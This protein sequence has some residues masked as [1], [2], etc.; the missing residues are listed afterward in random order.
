MKDEARKR[1]RYKEMRMSTVE[2]VKD[3]N[4]DWMTTYSSRWE[5]GN[6]EKL[7]HQMYTGITVVTREYTK[8]IGR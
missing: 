2:N 8:Y 1:I 4:L 5:G 7:S 3:G 6:K